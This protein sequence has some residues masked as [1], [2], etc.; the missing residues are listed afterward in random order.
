MNA[1]GGIRAGHPSRTA[2]TGPLAPY[3]DGFR[4]DLGGHPTSRATRPSVTSA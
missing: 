4:E 3:A 2:V 1:G